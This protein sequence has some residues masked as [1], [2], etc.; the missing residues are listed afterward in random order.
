MVV[1]PDYSGGFTSVILQLEYGFTVREFLAE[2]PAE[3]GGVLRGQGAGCVKTAVFPEDCGS[4]G[5]AVRVNIAALVREGKIGSQK[6]SGNFPVQGCIPGQHT[7]GGRRVI[8][9]GVGRQG[10]LIGGKQ[11]HQ[12]RDSQLAGIVLRVLPHNKGGHQKGIHQ[13]QNQ[14]DDIFQAVTIHFQ[15]DLLSILNSAAE[16]NLPASWRRWSCRR[17]RRSRWSVLRPFAWRQWPLPDVGEAEAKSHCSQH[18]GGA[19]ATGSIQ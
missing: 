14:N 13:H 9:D 8:G 17:C 18:T 2:F 11:L 6:E 1:V 5:A 16:I 19:A 7:A 12:L 10:D 15:P 4:S 3:V